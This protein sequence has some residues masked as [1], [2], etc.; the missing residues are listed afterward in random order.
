MPLL[1][2]FLWKTLNSYSFRIFNGQSIIKSYTCS[3]LWTSSVMRTEN[4]TKSGVNILRSRKHRRGNCHS[5]IK[6]L[7]ATLSSLTNYSANGEYINASA[8]DSK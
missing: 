2:P 6:L 8:M 3:S 4:M 1:Q 5:S 7:Y